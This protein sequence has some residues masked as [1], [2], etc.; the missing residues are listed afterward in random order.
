[1]KA[2]FNFKKTLYRVVILVAFMQVSQ[3]MDAQVTQI[4]WGD[5]RYISNQGIYQELRV[6]NDLSISSYGEYIIDTKNFFNTSILSTDPGYG[7]SFMSRF[8]EVMRLTDVVT[9][10]KNI[11]AK[12]NLT[13]DG[14]S[15]FKSETIF[16][17]YMNLSCTGKSS[18]FN[19]QS[20]NQ[21]NYSIGQHQDGS[22]FVWNQ[23]NSR[24]YFGT[25]ALERFSIAADGNAT[26]K[27]NLTVDGT[28]LFKDAATFTKTG[29]NSVMNF[30]NS[31]YFSAKNTEGTNEQYLVPRFSDDKMYL[32]IGNN[33]FIMRRYNGTDWNSF[34][35]TTD[36]NDKVQIHQPTYIGAGT[37]SAVLTNNYQL[38]IGGKLN[39]NGFTYIGTGT[40]SDNIKNNYLL[41]VDGKFVAKEV[42]ASTTEWADFVFDDSYELRDLS[43]VE[44]FIEENH[45]LPDVPSEKEVIEDGVNLGKMDA[46]LLQKIEELTLYVIQLEKKV[47]KLENK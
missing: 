18:Y 42:R 3:N 39:V 4:G 41:A 36:A 17:D 23:G 20:D 19:I 33:G 15:L 12:A 24:L 1:M 30:E 27:N 43:E 21:L 32:T 46:I 2:K 13:V 31:A 5:T 6:K 34:L 11:N 7:I 22:A 25:N 26:F 9:S 10:Y 16:N 38:A 35:I 47:D 14:A 37:P 28:S 29:H 8:D 40:P 45:H 44:E